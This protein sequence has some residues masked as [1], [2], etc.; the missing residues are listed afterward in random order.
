MHKSSIKTNAPSKVLWD[1]MRCWVEK[2]PVSDKRLTEGSVAKNILSIKPAQEYSFEMHID[3][4]PESKRMGLVRF[5][6]N[7]QPF[8]GPGTRATAMYVF[9]LCIFLL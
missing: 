9:I 6:E 3:A 2:N 7:P 1:I 4:N 8:W 5:Q